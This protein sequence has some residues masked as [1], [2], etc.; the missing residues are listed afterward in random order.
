[1]AIT[2]LRADAQI[3]QSTITPTELSASVV[4]NGLTGAEGTPLAVSSS[5]SS[6]VVSE[7]GIAAGGGVV[8]GSTQIYG[9]QIQ[10]NTASI[11]GVTITLGGT[12]ATP[13]FDLQDASGLPT[14]GLTGTITNAQLG[15]S[16]ANSK[17]VNDGITFNGYDTSLGDTITTEKLVSGT[18]IHSGSGDQVTVLKSLGSQLTLNGYKNGFTGSY[19]TAEMVSGQ[20]IISS[21]DQFVGTDD[22]VL[23]H[24]TASGN[25]SA[26]GYVSA[27]SFYGA[28]VEISSSVVFTS[29]SSIFGDESSDSHEFTGSVD[30]EGT[31]NVQGDLTLGGDVTLGNQTSDDITMTGR[32]ASDII[33][34]TNNTYDIGNGTNALADLH[35]SGTAYVQDLQAAGFSVGGSGGSNT[36][37]FSSIDVTNLFAS[38]GKIDNATLGKGG[39]GIMLDGNFTKVSASN[40]LISTVDINGGNIDGTAIGAS[41]TAAGTFTD[42]TSTG[43]TSLGNTG[44]MATPT[45]N[46]N[47]GGV[48]SG[49][50]IPKDDD[51]YNLGSSGKQW[52]D[53]HLNGTANID[54]LAADTA[55]ISSGDFVVGASGVT[56]LIAGG[57]LDIGGYN[58]RAQ[59]ITA[60]N[61][62]AARIVFTGDDGLLSEETGLEYT[63]SSNTFKVHTIQST[64]TF[65]SGGAV[66]A[67]PIGLNTANFGIFTYLTASQLES[68]I[69]SPQPPIVVQSNIK[70]DNLNADLLDG[71]HGSYYLDAGNMVYEAGDIPTTAIDGILSQWTGS[72]DTDG[73]GNHT[74]YR[75]GHVF[76]SSSGTDGATAPWRE[77]GSGSVTLSNGNVTAS[78][79][80]YKQ[81]LLNSFRFGVTAS[82]DTFDSPNFR[83]YVS[84]SIM[85]GSEM[86]FV[87]GML[88]DS[89]SDNDYTIQAKN[90]RTSNNH[91]GDNFITELSFNYK[92]PQKG[93]KVK[94]MYVPNNKCSSSLV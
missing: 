50:L 42:L 61:L 85:L 32:L 5:H 76:V 34:K 30:M 87:N 16:I 56:S 86:I 8:S 70:V 90:D 26:S 74:I 84:E 91:P 3:S 62:T 51:T 41:S 64:H 15:G 94:L 38:G 36:G 75:Q 21:S 69:N 10:S 12:D 49:S 89:G 72:T 24:V 45:D 65:I 73:G 19:S 54:A 63:A 18:T 43:N 66:D 28:F 46:I 71:N 58:F 33:P 17:L 39:G 80:I 57:H 27:S 2:R 88:Q 92:V 59:N 35:V 48:L 40:A 68:T 55:N 53:L 47:I 23:S 60:D 20:T 11:G 67:T 37:I 93:T 31:L 9:H 52:K 79:A 6:I 77:D 1:M 7:N 29:G 14:T 22:F 13:A 81:T 4:G 82:Y 78:G 25:I 83:W 44:E